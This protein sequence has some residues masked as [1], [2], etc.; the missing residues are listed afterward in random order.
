[1][2]G[3][4]WQNYQQSFPSDGT[5]PLVETSLNLF[6]VPVGSSIKRT[7]FHT[8][9]SCQ[10]AGTVPTSVPLDFSTR[11]VAG[12]GLWIGDTALPAANS[13]SV[14]TDANTESWL[15]WDTLQSRV[16]M[17]QIADTGLFRINWETPPQGL[18][19][20]TRRL[21]PPAISSDLWYAWEI[22][23][24]DG[25]INSSTAD[26]NAYLSGWFSIRFLIY[27]P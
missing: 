5:T 22:I 27:T 17:D 18:D 2:T 19:V 11:V 15:F 10:L 26:Y 23:D 16:D 25:V 7:L 4:S 12:V 13:P 24:P 8:Q 1:M 20:Q 9:L 21:A 6:T 3:Y 14:L